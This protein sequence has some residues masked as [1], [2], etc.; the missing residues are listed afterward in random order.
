MSAALRGPKGEE[1]HWAKV[2]GYSSFPKTGWLVGE[3]LGFLDADEYSAL[4]RLEP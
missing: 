4:F 2:S 3:G 1:R